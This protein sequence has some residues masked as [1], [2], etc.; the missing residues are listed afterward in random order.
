MVYLVD[1]TNAR[2]LAI[3]MTTGEQVADA[4]IDDGA[5]QGELVVSIDDNTLYLSETNENEIM[6]FSLPDLTPLP[7]LAIGFPAR[8]IASGVSGRLFAS[9]NTGPSASI[10][11]ELNPSTGASIQSFGS[12][13]NYYYPPL[14]R[15]NFDGTNLYAGVSGLTGNLNIYEYNLSGTQISAATP[16]SYNSENMIDFAPDET[17][18]RIYDMCGDIYGINLINTATDDD[19]TTWPFT[20]SYGA[21][22]SFNSQAS[23]V[24]GASGDPYK[25]DIREFDRVSGSPLADYVVCTDTWT[26]KN[27]GIGAMANGNVFY[28]RAP[29]VAASTSVLGVLGSLT[30]PVTLYPT[31]LPS[32]TFPPVTIQFVG[33]TATLQAT[34]SAGLP[35]TYTVISGPAVIIGSN[36]LKL[37]G[38]GTV[39]LQ[40]SE[41]GNAVFE[42]TQTTQ[43]FTVN[44]NSQTIAPFPTIPTQT[45]GE[46]S[47]TITF[48]TAS[49]GLPV[50]VTLVSGPA[51]LAGNRVTIT[52]AGTVTLAANQAG[53][54]VYAAAPE[55]T[56]SFVV[57]QEAQT[58]GS[59]KT[60]STKTYGANPFT[61]KVPTATSG[62]PVTLSVLSGPA[63][64]IGDTV[65]LTAS[66]TVVLAAD[67]AGNT[68]YSAAPEVTTSFV[69]NGKSQTISS[70]KTISAKSYSTTPFDI[71][72]PTASSGLPVTVT[73]LSGPATISGDQ[74]T[75]TGV[76]KVELAA[77]Q[78]GN[79]D[80][81]AAKQVTTSFTVNAASQTISAFQSIP[82]Q[83]YGVAPFEIGLPTSSVGLPVTVTVKSG[84]ATLSGDLLTIT[85]AGTVKLVANQAGDTDY[86][87]AKQVSTSF[88]V[89][90]A[91]QTL[92]A[93]TPISTQSYG[94]APFTITPPVAS[95]GL[96]VTVTVKSGPAKISGDTVTLTGVGTVELKAAQAGNSDY[97]AATS[98]TTTFT[99]QKGTQTISA[100]TPIGTQTLGEPAFTITPPTASSG[101]PVKVSVQSGPAKIS[102]NKVSVTGTGTVVLQATQ[103]GNSNYDAAATVTTSFTVD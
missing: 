103:A 72:L 92:P 25:G 14:L 53:S 2:L 97:Q 16:Y 90:K 91:S 89:E 87:A 7:T 95:S 29:Q 26:V 13:E 46:G 27:R 63:T 56:T 77:N 60:I 82:E 75:I 6:A 37:T 48:P 39:V 93:F 43:T 68:D 61:V 12:S 36:T 9:D 54:T 20:G 52:G 102:G 94:E 49:S 41:A 24:F 10:I 74:V 65:T 83:V 21:A 76:G 55:V 78:P 5:T 11:V 73:V 50:N 8:S 66:G 17:N 32:I 19:S 18:E 101:L 31:I 1:S 88:T 57:N 85:G 99:V 3:D 35:I 23:V 69:V 22:I 100:F 64:V 84:P 67:Q 4:T 96:A 86:A 38:A 42:S 45:F 47:F 98:V 71:T 40:A 70:F 81:A 28:V 44:L 79:D 80:Y 59:F 33:Q 51:T 15:T 62:L 34:D 58:I 30:Q